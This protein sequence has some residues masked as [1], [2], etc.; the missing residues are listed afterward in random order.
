M[1]RTSATWLK[2]FAAATAVI[3]ALCFMLSGSSLAQGI[4]GLGEL[5]GGGSKH[6]RSSSQSASTVTVDRGAAPFTGTFTGKQTTSSGTNDLNSRFAC[7]PA[8]DP[9]FA[10]TKTFVCYAAE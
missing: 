3:L 8:R 5:L 4:G 7:F 9:A 1:E 10:Q 6:S 2:G